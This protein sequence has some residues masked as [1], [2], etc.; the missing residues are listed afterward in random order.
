LSTLAGAVIIANTYE[1]KQIS[2]A[3]TNTDKVDADK[4]CRMRQLRKEAAEKQG[5]PVYAV[6]T[7]DHLASMVKNKTVT[8]GPL[9]VLPC[10]YYNKINLERQED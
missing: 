5:L 1:L 4:L 10:P 6:F 8:F 7:N 3:R 9:A 2:L